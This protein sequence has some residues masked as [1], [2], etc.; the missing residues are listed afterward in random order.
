MNPSV[1]KIGPLHFQGIGPCMERHV[2]KPE[3]LILSNS[4]QTRKKKKKKIPIKTGGKKRKR[5]LKFSTSLLSLIIK[6]IGRKKRKK[7]N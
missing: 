6:K 4:F 5:I 3:N 2:F 7:E 1:T